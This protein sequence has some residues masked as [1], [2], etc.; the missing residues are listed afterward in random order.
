MQKLYQRRK[1]ARSSTFHRHVH[2]LLHDRQR[3]DRDQ[4]R[5]IVQFLNG[6]EEDEAA[7]AAAAAA[8]NAIGFCCM[9]RVRIR[10]WIGSTGSIIVG[11]Q[12]PTPLEILFTINQRSQLEAKT[13]LPN[14]KDDRES[15]KLLRL[16]KECVRWS[17]LESLSPRTF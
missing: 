10:V 16:A 11:Y 12:K 15:S 1:E 6:E 8:A 3:A 7:A 17:L 4:I 14:L 2:F 5:T 13:D 9:F